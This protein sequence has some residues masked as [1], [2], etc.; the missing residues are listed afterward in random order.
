MSGK[1]IL[2][3]LGASIAVGTFGALL[4]L[5]NRRPLRRSTESKLIRN[6]RNLTVAGF[7]AVAL[8]LAEQPIAA[9]LTKLVERKKIG[10]LKIFRLPPILE[11]ILAVIL[12]DYTLYVWHVLTH[13]IPFC[14][15][16]TRFITLI[17]IWMLRPL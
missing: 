4:Y 10:L 8:Q 5:E 12:M 9:P 1:K 14:G 11:L 6:A 16:F 17:W 7:A 13:K 3:L 2:K 15:G